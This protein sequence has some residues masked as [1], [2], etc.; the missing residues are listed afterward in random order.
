LCVPLLRY[1]SSSLAVSLFPTS[2]KPCSAA[3]CMCSLGSPGFGCVVYRYVCAAMSAASG[4]FGMI[5]RCS[6]TDRKDKLRF[7]ERFLLS[8]CSR[9]LIH[10][11]CLLC[12]LLF[13]CDALLCASCRAA[14]ATI[15]E[16]L[17]FLFRFFPMPVVL[18]VV[19]GRNDT[20]E[21]PL[22][23]RLLVWLHRARWLL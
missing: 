2:L 12:L 18:I 3:R 13:V 14:L 19:E 8:E 1:A 5:L 22:C 7:L 11:P 10:E 20:P 4:V 15:A 17:L 16:S 6:S 9:L 23:L 21:V